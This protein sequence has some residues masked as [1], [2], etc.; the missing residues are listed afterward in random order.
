[1]DKCKKQTNEPKEKHKP[2]SVLQ[3]LPMLSVPHLPFLA[4]LQ[5]KG[6]V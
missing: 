4:R 3:P 2:S 1:M 5:T 6:N